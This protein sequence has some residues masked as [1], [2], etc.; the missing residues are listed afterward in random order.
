MAASPLDDG[1]NQT[2][3]M[4]GI[5]HNTVDRRVVLIGGFVP[6]ITAGVAVACKPWEVAARHLQPDAVAW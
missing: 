4:R 3:R 2:R 1:K 6:D 5:M